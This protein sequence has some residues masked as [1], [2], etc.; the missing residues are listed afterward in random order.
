MN[1]I[2]DVKTSDSPFK[3]LFAVSGIAAMLD[4]CLTL[5]EVIGFSFYPQP[6]TVHEWFLTQVATKGS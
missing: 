3:E 4:G 1:Q 2:T 5:S 6:V